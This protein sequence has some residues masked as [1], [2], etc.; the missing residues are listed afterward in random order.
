MDKWTLGLIAVA[1]AL[2]FFASR[3]AR[4]AHG[5]VSAVASGSH[6]ESKSPSSVSRANTDDGMVVLRNEPLDDGMVVRSPF[7]GDQGMA[8]NVGSGDPRWPSGAQ[9]PPTQS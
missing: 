2:G 7:D 4:K 8:K 3:D 6:L 9:D 1:A 5:S